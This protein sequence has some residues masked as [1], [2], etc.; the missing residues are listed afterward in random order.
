MVPVLAT[1]AVQVDSGA[2]GGFGTISGAVTIGRNDPGN[3]HFSSPVKR[4]AIPAHSTILNSLTFASDGFF[5]VGLG[6]DSIASKVVAKAVTI[7]EGAQFAYANNHGFSVPDGT[8]L[9]VIDN[10]GATPIAGTFE[11]LP[12]GFVFTD[13][14]NRFVVTYEAAT[15]MI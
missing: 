1:G 5:N 9:T 11:N 15:A 6:R 2:L 8:V 10:T 13:H 14:G 7:Q 3:V 12:E 4:L